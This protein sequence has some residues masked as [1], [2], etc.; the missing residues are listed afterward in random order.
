LITAIM[1]QYS[2]NGELLDLDQARAAIDPKQV[3]A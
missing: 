3:P 1:H 2:S